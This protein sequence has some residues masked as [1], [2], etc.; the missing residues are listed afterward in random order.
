MAKKQT[1]LEK[2]MIS[3]YSKLNNEMEK[4]KVNEEEKKVELNKQ[5][6]KVIYGLIIG[7]VVSLFGTLIIKP[8]YQLNFIF[9]L[10]SFGIIFLSVYTL[11]DL[12]ITKNEERHRY[13]T[14][15]IF[16]V[17]T[18]LILI[19]QFAILIHQ[20]N[21][22]DEQKNIQRQQTSIIE[23][24]SQ[25]PYPDLII[26]SSQGNQ[27]TKFDSIVNGTNQIGVGVLNIGKATAPYASVSLEDS[28]F[29]GTQNYYNKN[30][31][32]SFDIKDLESGGHNSTWFE[33]W[34]NPNQISNFSIGEKNITFKID[35]PVC[36][37]PI[38]YQNVSLCVFNQN[39]EECGDK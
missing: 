24:T 19:G 20:T 5:Q 34:I 31:H 38:S 10:I 1:E 12:F 3:Y 9:S 36:R 14:K 2:E 8:I 21:I 18:I 7:L 35:C 17:L 32:Y 11:I 27:W 15:L 28:V 25:S 4:K 23:K 37:E 22:L 6:K 29:I 16:N 39:I 33:F 30:N 26:T 13:Y